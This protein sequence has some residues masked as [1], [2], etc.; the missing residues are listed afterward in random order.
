MNVLFRVDASVQIGTGHVMRCL[1]LAERL[2][3]EQADISFMCRDLP[4]DLRHYLME[5]G[6]K[7][8]SLPPPETASAHQQ[9]RSKDDS[10]RA[11][12]A[13]WL[14]V[15]QCRDAYET[16]AALK[17]AGEK[18]DWLV[19]DHYALGSD[20]ERELRPHAAKVMVIDDLADRPHECDLLLDQN[21]QEPGRYSGL[22]PQG[23]CILAG[24]RYA[25][26][27]PQFAAARGRLSQRKGNVSQVLVFF[28][29]ADATGATLNALAAIKALNHPALNVDVIVGQ[30]NPHRA[31][32]EAAC[33]EIPAATLR[34]QVD[35]M[36]QRMV[37][38]DLY[39]GAGG[40]SSWERCCLGLPAIVLATAENQVPQAEA[41][42][43]A[44]AQIYAGR[45]DQNDIESV[46]RLLEQVLRLPELLVHMS[47]RGRELVDGCGTA[48]VAN[49]I[50]S[51][52]VHLR[53]AT[54]ADSARTF[55]WRNHS[56]T[57]RFCFDSD[58]IERES[59]ERWFSNSL[60]GAQREILIAE[61]GGRS[62]GVL[63]YDMAEQGAV[64]SIY[65]VPGLA[66]RGWGKRL[67]LAGENWLRDHY[68]GIS[69]VEA[70][71]SA[72]NRPSLKAFESAGYRPERM[73][74]RK[75]IAVD[76][77]PYPH[78]QPGVS[79]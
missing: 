68:P 22:A 47:Q 49:H 25:L 44:G 67:L 19:V 7:V 2:R 78:S 3:E 74:Y 51:H 76:G 26:L 52:A 30:A 64:V 9:V 39:V 11:A 61:Q 32:I 70:E 57:R 79:L 34:S 35:D 24:P 75:E 72:S 36:A 60:A 77:G 1:T 28:G 43:R 56:D 63:R 4:G 50:L 21:L 8:H 5:R 48:R 46:A 59:H 38:A 62:L 41:L 27:R 54:Q 15:T 20:W 53:R 23:C 73:V 40:T 13:D 37:E 12:Y 42:A 6:F 10:G 18:V 65:L 58:P 45:S 66:G 33:R 14:G 16:I 69:R 71:I 29:G 31:D 17:S 55:E